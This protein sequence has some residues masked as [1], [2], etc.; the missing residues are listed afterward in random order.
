MGLIAFLLLCVIVGVIVWAAV[1]Y[2]PMP[3]QFKTAL[4]V[5]AI[6]VLI[7]ILLLHVLGGVNDVPIPRLR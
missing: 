6:I 2:V 1:T 4:P 3:P 7:L 5:I